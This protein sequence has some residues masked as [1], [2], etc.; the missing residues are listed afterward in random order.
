M[1]E[2]IEACPHCDS[3][4]FHVRARGTRGRHSKDSAKR[5]C[6]DCQTGFETPIERDRRAIG[7]D[8]QTVLKNAGFDVSEAMG[9]D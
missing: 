5:Y 2:T 1:S 6:E 9:D 4:N 8:A 7:W 3:T